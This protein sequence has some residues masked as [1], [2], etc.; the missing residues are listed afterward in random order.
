MAVADASVVDVLFELAATSLFA[1]HADAL[2]HAVARWLPWFDTEP[3]AGIHPLRAAATSQGM[4]VLARR[5]RLV[6][7]VPA[8]RAA[9]CR[10]LCG[11]MLDVAG[12]AVDVGAASER[13]LAPSATLYA[14]RV[15]AATDDE[16]AFHEVVA[17]WLAETGVRCEFISGRPHRFA[18]GAREVVGFGLALHGLSPADSIRVQSA[19]M[20]GDRRLGCGIFVPHKA[21]ATPA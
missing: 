20:G 7:R 5:A 1:D 2:A 18:A 9:D 4:V 21:I 13:P 11:R 10:T 3:A 17:R 12:S 19:G 6:L 16:R 8:S 14:R 15:A